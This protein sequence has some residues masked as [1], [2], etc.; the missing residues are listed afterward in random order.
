ME[1]I[2]ITH[3]QYVIKSQGQKS[4]DDAYGQQFPHGIHLYYA[5]SW[6]Y[7]VLK[8][9][10]YKESMYMYSYDI[11]ENM[12]SKYLVFVCLMSNVSCL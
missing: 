2:K 8:A 7:I 5:Y 6:R 12:L 10:S 11:T 9:T 3:K 4:Y 1:E